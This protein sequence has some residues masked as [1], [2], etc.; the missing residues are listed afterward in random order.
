M[1]G[2]KCTNQCN[3]ITTWGWHLESSPQLYL[4]LPLGAKLAKNRIYIIFTQ[5]VETHSP[6]T[7]HNPHARIIQLLRFL[8]RVYTNKVCLHA[9]KAGTRYN[10]FQRQS[11]HMRRAQ[12][13]YNE[14]IVVLCYRCQFYSC[15]YNTRLDSPVGSYLRYI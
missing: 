14:R 7:P 13:S 15:K 10:C 4:R 8:N 11:Y 6:H 9:R 12:M 5:C 2:F 1:H 3:I